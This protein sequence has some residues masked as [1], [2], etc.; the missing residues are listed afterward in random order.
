MKSWIRGAMGAVVVS[1]LASLGCAGPIGPQGQTGTPGPQ[2]ATGPQGTPGT[3][4]VDPSWT[5]VEKAVASL[6]G[7][8]AVT[9]MTS[10]EIS[11]TG[12]RFMSL[13]GWH[14][15]DDSIQV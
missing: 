6:G 11:A 15:D 13:E 10:V 2:G 4:A 7:Q 1:I 9:G 14:P 5:A 8:A 12:Q 3:P